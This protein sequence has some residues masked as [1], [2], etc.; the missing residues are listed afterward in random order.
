LASAAEIEFTTTEA[1][2]VA[3][4]LL[5]VRQIWNRRAILKGWILGTIALG[6]LGFGLLSCAGWRLLLAPVI[7]AA[8]MA[9]GALVS[10]QLFVRYA[11]RSFRQAHAFFRSTQLGWDSDTVRFASDRGEVRW[12]WA[13]FYAWAANDR[14]ILLYQTANSFITVPVAGFPSA[15][16]TQIVSALEA[17]GVLQRSAR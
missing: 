5:H 10:R 15:T 2:L 6:L 4:N 17:A 7:A 1:D 13:D 11:R 3:G 14:S 12:R 8:Y 9:V 16:K